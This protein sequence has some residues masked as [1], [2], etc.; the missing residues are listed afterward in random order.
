MFTAANFYGAS[1]RK[2]QNKMLRVFRVIELFLILRDKNTGNRLIAAYA[3]PPRGK[4]KAPD[5][6]RL[7][8]LKTRPD[9]AAAITSAGGARRFRL[10]S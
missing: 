8:E 2:T 6:I 1:K 9:V 10:L 5:D 4:S 7:E 3:E